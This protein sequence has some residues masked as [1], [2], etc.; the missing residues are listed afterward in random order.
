[1]LMERVAVSDIWTDFTVESQVEGAIKDVEE[2]FRSYLNGQEV[3]AKVKI[4]GVSYFLRFYN[5]DPVDVFANLKFP[6]RAC[7]VLRRIFMI[8]GPLA[9]LAH[10]DEDKSN[11]EL[12]LIPSLMSILRAAAIASGFEFPVFIPERSPENCSFRGFAMKGGVSENYISH[13]EYVHPEALRSL[14]V[15]ADHF[16]CTFKD[17]SS[18][19]AS[20]RVQYKLAN[21]W[22]HDISSARSSNFYDKNIGGF[23]DKARVWAEWPVVS[24][25]HAPLDIEKAEN[26]GIWVRFRNAPESHS[27]KLHRFISLMK[28]FS[29][30]PN[31]NDL[32]RDK[33][34]MSEEV[35]RMFTEVGEKS[36]GEK[37][38]LKASPNHS[39]VSSLAVKLVEYTDDIQS[40]ASFWLSFLKELRHSFEKKRKL[41]GVDD[42]GPDFDNCLIYQK[43]QMINVCINGGKPL[44]LD[45]S[46][47]RESTMKLLNG[48]VMMIPASQQGGIFTEDQ[49]MDE[50]L[51]LENNVGDQR[52]KA[53]LQRAALMRD[54]IAF[55]EVNANASFL[56]FIRWYSPRDYNSETNEL[57]VRMA[58]DDNLWR[59]FWAD[60]ETGKAKV[61]EFSFNA[62]QQAELALDYLEGISPPELVG[63]LVPVLLSAAFFGVTETLDE[64]LENKTAMQSVIDSLNL[65]HERV[66]KSEK[67]LSGEEYMNVSLTCSEIIEESAWQ[68]D[69]ANALLKVLKDCD[70][71][72][73]LLGPA[74]NVFV[75]TDEQSRN[76]VHA[77][78][79]SF[80][81]SDWE[82]CENFNEYSITGVIPGP[83]RQR[84]YVG[85]R[86]HQKYVVATS[87]A[88]LL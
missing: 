21:P 56:D 27:S 84:I 36:L 8:H 10:H 76:L 38:I 15:I 31:W 9:V 72:N 29:E 5:E 67:R 87:F 32:L 4:Y 40:L 34:N 75:A 65:F 51:L 12:K 26:Y 74:R 70:L 44:E 63:D 46:K 2:A 3:N 57:S 30:S 64:K 88:D 6:K 11:I 69:G 60:V 47:P 82:S 85:D 42:N 7:D 61:E 86:R 35:Q 24:D 33:N 19:E 71:V 78:V 52:Q 18:L 39:L 80:N 23:V 48:E 62:V 13:Y 22:E 20:V 66:E 45:D 53:F 58:S 41:P 43:L 73:I 68:I 50:Q 28:S 59:E 49:I 83:V 1:M 79:K 77:L 17:I 55:K 37:S 81:I 14:P 16:S 25:V 54:M